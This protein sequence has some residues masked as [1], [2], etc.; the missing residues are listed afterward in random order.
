MALFVGAIAATMIASTAVTSDVLAEKG[1][2]AEHIPDQA[3]C[4]MADEAKENVF[5]EKIPVCKK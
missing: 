1:K 3:K 5:G 2:A 4:H